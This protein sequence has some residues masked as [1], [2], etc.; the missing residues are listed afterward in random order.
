MIIQETLQ[1]SQEIR[2]QV[3]G[4][5]L[6]ITQSGGPVEIRAG[7]KL[8]VKMDINDRLYLTDE[9]GDLQQSIFIKNISGGENAIEIITSEL[10][11]DK[12]TSA[13]LANALVSIAIGQRIGID[14]VAN[15]VQASIT[16][17]IHLALGQYIGIDPNANEVNLQAGAQVGI[18]PAANTVQAAITNAI[19]LTVGQQ[20]GIDPDANEISLAAGSEINLIHNKRQYNALTTVTITSGTASIAANS[21]REQLMLSADNTNAEKIWLG[22]TI[23]QGAYIAPGE[24]STIHITE[25]LTLSGTNNDKLYVAE[26]SLL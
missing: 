11:I 17:A 26:V 20:I 7:N 3:D 10:L 8:A 1:P 13:D 24:K 16:N 12:R 5:Y 23:G 6:I 18:D 9:K 2:R 21:N 22:S 19:N 14:P 4:R 25:T 15:I